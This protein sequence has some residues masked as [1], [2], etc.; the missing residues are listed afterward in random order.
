MPGLATSHAHRLHV[1]PIAVNEQA[2]ALDARAVL[3]EVCG[4]ELELERYL[5][6][7]LGVEAQPRRPLMSRVGAKDVAADGPGAELEDDRA[8]DRAQE[9]ARGRLSGVEEEPV[10]LDDEEQVVAAQHSK[11]DAADDVAQKHFAVFVTA[12]VRCERERDPAARGA[13]DGVL[14][15]RDDRARL[16]NAEKSGRGEAQPRVALPSGRDVAELA[17]HERAR[18]ADDGHQAVPAS[19][20][21]IAAGSSRPRTRAGVGEALAE[22]LDRELRDRRN[23]ERSA[24]SSS[25]SGETPLRPSRPSSLEVQRL[26]R[27]A[28]RPPARSS[29]PR[30]APPLAHLRASG[31]PC[32]TTC[33]RRAMRARAPPPSNTPYGA[34]SSWGRSCEMTRRFR[35]PRFSSSSSPAKTHRLHRR[36]R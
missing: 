9:L 22:R 6:R 17:E 16:E 11:A 23:P 24:T 1:E 20:H 8:V 15:R 34:A 28:A 10:V 5:G 27:D 18:G 33:G 36:P 26:E 21:W 7:G 13:V 31:Y 19:G 14:A 30:G 2:I 35:R 25:S 32:S 4:A 12:R 29:R 3:R